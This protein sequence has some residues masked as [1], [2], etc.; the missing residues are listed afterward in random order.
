M[1]TLPKNL[2][3][4]YPAQNLQRGHPAQDL[5]RARFWRLALTRAVRAVL[6]M[7]MLQQKREEERERSPQQE[8]QSVQP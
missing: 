2:I 7:E 4:R 5:Q 6:A 8:Y 3:A 1:K